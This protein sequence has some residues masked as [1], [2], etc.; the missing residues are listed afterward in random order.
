[1]L[2]RCALL[3]DVQYI[4]DIQIRNYPVSLHEDIAVIA[5]YVSQ[6]MSMV[7]YND[8]DCVIGYL[9]CHFI[10]DKPPRY[11]EYLHVSGQN[12]NSLFIHDLCIDRCH[13]CKGGASLLLDTLRNTRYDISLISLPLSIHFWQHQGFVITD[14]HQDICATYGDGSVHM[15]RYKAFK[16]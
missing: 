3:N 15:K 4:Y 16:S 5:D 6:G 2:T 13:R 10:D 8:T 14:Q 7:L 11:N 12:T 1:M 9:L